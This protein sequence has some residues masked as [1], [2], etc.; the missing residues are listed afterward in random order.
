MDQD[1][2][3]LT[4]QFSE[5]SLPPEQWPVYAQLFNQHTFVIDGQLLD[6]TSGLVSIEI[7][8]H[9]DAAMPFAHAY[10]SL[11]DYAAL[12][13]DERSSA[14]QFTGGGI[15]QLLRSKKFML[16]ITIGEKIYTISYREL[17][18]L[19]FHLLCQGEP[20]PRKTPD[21]SVPVLK[22]LQQEI[23]KYCA[24]HQD[25]LRCWV[26]L[27]DLQADLVMVGVALDSYRAREHEFP[28]WDIVL[29]LLEP[30]HLLFILEPETPQFQEINT[31]LREM[32]PIYD[33]TRKKG[34][35]AKIK[36]AFGVQPI[37]CMN[38]S[39]GE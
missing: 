20:R 27:V 4:K 14:F 17:L 31:R 1:F 35:F 8:R 25:I 9:P 39:N 7:R 2:Q 19:S 18:I 34:F 5:G 13:E 11:E 23:A 16:V 3:E 32:P 15:F 28:I 10:F 37:P 30:G 36:G 29:G 21:I 24:S 33:A 12:P 22:Q 6:T 26:C 38:F